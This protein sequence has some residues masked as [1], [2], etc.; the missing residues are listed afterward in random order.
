LIHDGGPDMLI[1]AAMDILVPALKSQGT[2]G[3]IAGH[4]LEIQLAVMDIDD[5]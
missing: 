1:E 4:M 3:A 2:S 5:C